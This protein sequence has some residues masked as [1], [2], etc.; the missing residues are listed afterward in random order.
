M[1]AVPRSSPTSTKT[2]ILDAARRRFEHYGLSKVTMDEIS[3]DVGL[4]KAS[5]YYYFATKESLF[6][7]V[8]VREHEAF[9]KSMTPQVDAGTSSV[10]KLRLFVRG[11]FGYFLRLMNL[12]VLDL[13]SS[14]KMKPVMRGLF[15]E[16]SRKE[17]SILRNIIAEGKTGGELCVD[18][19]GKT[20]E[21]I[22]H[23]MRGLRLQFLQHL[24]RPNVSPEEWEPLRQEC[25]L[26]L[27]LLLRGLVSG[28]RRRGQA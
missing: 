1:P 4:G 16:F 20:A 9:L 2:E 19:P 22:V 27:D 17:V 11:R 26:V 8:L 21:A 3:H 13:A 10:E 14:A 25:N 12:Q 7:A 23:T 6:K 28:E 18:S 24:D 15:E 5:L